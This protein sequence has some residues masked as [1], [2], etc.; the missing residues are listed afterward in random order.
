MCKVVRTIKSAENWLFSCDVSSSD[1][2]RP[3][4]CSPGARLI[5]GSVQRF[6]GGSLFFPT[7]I[8]V[9]MNFVKILFLGKKSF[10]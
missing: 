7:L 2:R 5:G 8:H 9:A 6:V 3:T 1:Q 10:V 4:F